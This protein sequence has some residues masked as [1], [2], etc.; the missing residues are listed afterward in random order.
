MVASFYVRDTLL[1]LRRGAVNEDVEDARVIAVLQQLRRSV[2]PL[3]IGRTQKLLELRLNKP[4]ELDA[5]LLPAAERRMLADNRGASLGSG[6][7]AAGERS[8]EEDGGDREQRSPGLSDPHPSVDA[9]SF[10]SA[11]A[12]EAVRTSSRLVPLPPPGATGRM[13]S[14]VRVTFRAPSQVATSPVNSPPASITI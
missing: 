10:A 1:A 4:V 5:R 2:G 8:G 14:S 11:T 13:P 6:S 12:P 7:G 9:T 3:E